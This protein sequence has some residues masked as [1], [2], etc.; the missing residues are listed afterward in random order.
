M[1]RTRNRRSGWRPLVLAAV[2]L[3]LLSACAPAPAGQNTATGEIVTAFTGDL[4]AS[5]TASGRVVAQR[6]AALSVTAPGR[7]TQ[8]YVRVGDT[9]QSGEALLQLD[10]A[11]LALNAAAAEQNLRLQEANLAGLREAP[12]AADVA[13]AEAAVA[14]AQ[15][16]LDDLLAGPS[17][18]ELAVSAAGVRSAEASLWSASAQLAS[19]EDS[20]SPA[21]VQQAEA[22]LLAA[23]A[24]LE[25]ARAVN[26]ANPTQ[27]TDEALKAAEQAVANAQANLDNLLA[28]AD[29]SAAASS[30]A[31]ASARLDGSQAD[32]NLAA[33]GPTAVELASVQAQLAQAEAS[34]AALIDGPTVEEVAAAEAKV[35]QARLALADAQDALAGATLTAPFD[36]L[37]TAV[38]V[39]PGEIAGGVVVEVVD[40]RSLVV[41][42]EVDEMDVGALAAGQAA[43]VTLAAWPGVEI[44]S[45]VQTI[46]PGPTAGASTSIATYEV[47]LSLAETT[48]PIRVGMTA[49][50]HLLTTQREG[51][52]LVPNRAIQVDRATGTYT[53]KLAQGDSI[54]EITVTVGLRDDQNTQILNGLQEG[55]RL[56]I[57]ETPPLGQIGPGTGDP[58]GPGD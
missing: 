4:S 27:E 36:G 55:D 7:V 54:Q 19:A 46:A 25:R 18:T 31:A 21:Q 58:F 6:A 38:T 52:L 45:Q 11:D 16:S 37:V 34:L 56:L 22:A 48:L 10:T 35:E 5:V 57:G 43:V 8:V 41:V 44:E 32:Y 1:M 15:A 23:Q 39:S 9:V 50:A 20:I 51:V 14:S 28:G 29:T 24:S 17:E 3:F 26:E 47:Y 13:A 2:T 33:A 40:S 30:V 12:G 42:L 53:V 49:D